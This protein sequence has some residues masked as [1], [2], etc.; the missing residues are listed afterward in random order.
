MGKFQALIRAN[1]YYFNLAREGSILIL[2]IIVI[3]IINIIGKKILGI[4]S[5]D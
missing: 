3:F 2:V 1:S 5:L 4:N